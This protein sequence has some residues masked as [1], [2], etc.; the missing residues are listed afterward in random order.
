M[1]GLRRR[2]GFYAWGLAAFAVAG[3]PGPAL[4]Q[5]PSDAGAGAGARASQAQAALA[6]GEALLQDKR[7]GEAAAK[8]EEAIAADSTLAPAWYSLA[9]A[10]R[11]A[12]RCDLAIVAYR[13]VS[14][15]RPGEADPYY[16]LGL[17]LRE[18]GD[19][20]GAI[21]ALETYVARE[22]RA[23]SQKWVDRARREMA[24][25]Q[26]QPAP[27][28]AAAPP[29][30]PPPAD[31]FTAAPAAEDVSTIMSRGDAA[32][33][34]GRYQDAAEM[35]E[36]AARKAPLR[37]E[38]RYQWGIAFILMGRLSDASAALADAIRRDGAHGLA[39]DRLAQVK[40]KLRA[41]QSGEALPSAA[42]QASDHLRAGRY[43]LAEAEADRTL[44]TWPDAA[45]ALC[46]R[47]RARLER[48]AVEDARRDFLHALA[49]A[50]ADAA[51][52]RGLSDTYAFDGDRERAAYYLE[53]H[54]DAAPAADPTAAARIARQL[55]ELRR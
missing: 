23:E 11:R 30:A 8:L 43:A 7:F 37:A 2:Y 49:I 17:C 34:E 41:T 27:A 15:M 16:G 33:A 50:P 21:A 42:T 24:A 38:P 54:C 39:R 26:D 12:G 44:G 55:H 9:Y 40:K 46:V 52:L 3:A 51:A 14:E 18:L 29:P 45:D 13:K 4:A 6:K 47:G 53:L 36:L 10:R 35:F 48:G 19:R 28:P 20:P 25:M 32:M 1:T 31:K 5:S 22:R